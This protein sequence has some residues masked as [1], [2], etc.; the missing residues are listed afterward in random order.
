M[1]YKLGKAPA[2][3][4]AIKFK[5]SEYGKGLPTPPKAAGHL[6]LFSADWGMLGNDQYG[7]CVWAGAA[8]ETMLWNKEAQK[9]V[10]FDDSH[11]LS[12][13]TAVTGFDPTDPNTDQGTDMQVAAS[14]RRKTGVVDGS[15]ARHQVAAYLGVT[16]VKQVKQAVWLFGAAGIGIKFPSSAME[17]FKT[18][19]PWT[20]QAS[21]PIDGGH[22][23]PAV[24]YDEKYLYVVTWGKVQKATWG[25]V[26]KYMDEGI[27][28]LSD[29]ML[30]GGKTIDGLDIAT[31]QADI[32]EL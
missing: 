9:D 4:G 1:E 14:Y 2:R 12:D 28:Y 6:G 3:K 15:G 10:A 25:F 13:Y 11:V 19:K 23:I 22:Y 30:T 31:L 8:H 29:E 17:Q 21:S 32:A 18:G 20:V 26:Q 27:C 7:D 5:L 16:T 24:N